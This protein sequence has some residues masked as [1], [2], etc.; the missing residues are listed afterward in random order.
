MTLNNPNLA[1]LNNES[2]WVDD[3]NNG[4]IINLHLIFYQLLVRGMFITGILLGGVE[5]M[6]LFLDL[7]NDFP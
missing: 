2:Q 7:R 3:T 6:W 1:G 4:T 5:I